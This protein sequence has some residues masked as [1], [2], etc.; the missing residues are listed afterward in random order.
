MTVFLVENFVVKPDKQMEF[1]AYKEKWKKFFAPLLKELKSYRMFSQMFDGSYGG[2]VEMWEFESL[3]DLEKFF[4]K[5]KSD[6]MKKFYPEF[7]SLI[8]PGAYSM[9]VW[10]SVM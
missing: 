3:A 9:S 8:V 1:L 10:N 2:F 6:Y 4:G 5:V 7:A